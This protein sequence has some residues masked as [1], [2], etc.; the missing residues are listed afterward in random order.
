MTNAE[1]LALGPPIK[2]ILAPQA[3]LYLWATQYHLPVAF[4]CLKAWGFTWSTMLL[5][6]KKPRGRPGFPTWP[7]WV[8]YCLFARRGTL[9]TLKM[10]DTNVYEFPR[11]KHSQ[12]PPEFRQMFTETSPG[13]RLELFARPDPEGPQDQPYGLPLGWRYMGLETSGMDV[14]EELELEAEYIWEG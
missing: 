13:P 11:A 8:E 12:K 6:V 5:W 2:R 4:E 1:I 10:H 14:R 3:H 7:N 9:R